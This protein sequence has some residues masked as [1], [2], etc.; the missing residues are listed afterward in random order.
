[1]ARVV[2]A[3]QLGRILNS[4]SMEQGVVFDWV[5]NIHRESMYDVL[6]RESK[7]VTKAKEKYAELKGKLSEA[8]GNVKVFSPE[9]LKEYK[10]CPI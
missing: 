3:Q 8:K 5:D 7:K 9:E 6:G 4:G 2:Y 10:R 1:M